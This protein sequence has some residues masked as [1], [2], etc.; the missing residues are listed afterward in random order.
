MQVVQ[1]RHESPMLPHAAALVPGRQLSPLS[2]QPMQVDLQFEPPSVATPPS[3]GVQTPAWQSSVA[4]HRTHASPPPPHD[5]AVVAV[6]QVL[7]WQHPLAQFDGPHCVWHWP[8][9]QMRFCAMQST[10]VAPPAPQALVAEPA[11]HTPFWQQPLQFAHAPASAAPPAVPPPAE[12]PPVPASVAAQAAALHEAP[13]VPHAPDAVPG[14]QAPL[15]SQQPWHKPGPQR[16]EPH[17]ARV[18]RDSARSSRG[19]RVVMGRCGR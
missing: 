11:R 18:S 16:E 12:P 8:L 1:F 3:V 14:W 7:P 9:T 17:A 5:V 2:Q 6:T 10:Q 19:S 15:E 4:S 13:L